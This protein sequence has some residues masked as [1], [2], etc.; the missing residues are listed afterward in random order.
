MSEKTCYLIL[1][2]CALALL[3]MTDL[4]P[5]LLVDSYRE[6]IN[7]LMVRYPNVVVTVVLLAIVVGGSVAGY[8]DE[9]KRQT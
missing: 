9:K 2:F 1:F 8:L 3:S 6:W 4:N 7:G 5:L